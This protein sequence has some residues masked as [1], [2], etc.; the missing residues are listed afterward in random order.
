MGQCLCDSQWTGE[1]CDVLKCKQNNCS[2]NGV[3]SDQG[4]TYSATTVTGHKLWI[5][6]KVDQTKQRLQAKIAKFS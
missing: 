2:S 3:C 6:T 5:P 4:K 1:A